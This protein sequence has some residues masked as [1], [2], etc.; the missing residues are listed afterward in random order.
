VEAA[1][2]LPE[3]QNTDFRSVCLEG[4]WIKRI[5]HGHEILREDVS[6]LGMDRHG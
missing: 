5:A 2:L 3:I 1:V 6:L 4:L